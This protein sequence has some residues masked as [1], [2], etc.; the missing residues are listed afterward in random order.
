MTQSEQTVLAPGETYY[1]LQGDPLTLQETAQAVGIGI[2]TLKK[3]RD[4][5][6]IQA[7][8]GG[9]GKEKFIPSHDGA[10]LQWIECHPHIAALIATD[11]EGL[12][13]I[14]AKALHEIEALQEQA[15]N[16]QHG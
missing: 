15:N 13:S 2:L 6:K 5:L 9:V 8:K 12:A 10:F 4:L 7:I 1:P 14:R 3:R 11:P 16:K